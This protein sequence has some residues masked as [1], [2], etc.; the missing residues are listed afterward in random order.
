[1]ERIIDKISM[2]AIIFGMLVIAS[3]PFFS[4]QQDKVLEKE[5]HET[6]QSFNYVYLEYEPGGWGNDACWCRDVIEN[7]P[8]QVG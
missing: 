8:V 6:C 1:M 3:L 4:M 5:C 7:K 2:F